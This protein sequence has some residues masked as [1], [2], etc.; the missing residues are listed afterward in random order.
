MIGSLKRETP[1]LY[2]DDGRKNPKGVGD[3][4]PHYIN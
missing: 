1:Q 4:S 2:I 3:A